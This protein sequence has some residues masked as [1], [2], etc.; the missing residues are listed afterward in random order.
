MNVKEGMKPTITEEVLIASAGP[1][2][3]ACAISAQRRGINPLVIDAGAV[4]NSIVHY[5]VG[6]VFF[7][8][9]ERLEIGAHPLVCAGQ[10]PTREEAVKNYRGVALTESIRLATYTKLVDAQRRPDAIHCA[11]AKRVGTDHLVSQRLILA[12][13]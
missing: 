9:P 11:L 2:G 6:M 1:I 12:T 4:A 7:T 3:L 8:T 13:G 5:P 10:K